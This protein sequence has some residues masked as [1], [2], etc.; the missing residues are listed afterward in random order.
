MQIGTKIRELRKQRNL[1]LDELSEKS[2]VAL[3][4]LSRIENNKMKGTLASHQNICKA[5]NISIAE[6]YQTLENQN[7]TVESVPLRKRAEHVSGS[8]KSSFE[9]LVAKAVGKKILPLLLTIEADGQTQEENNSPGVEK[10][11]YILS[12][13]VNA[14][15]GDNSYELRPGDSLY[16]DAS[17]PHIFRN[18]NA[19]KAEAI[20]VIAPPEIK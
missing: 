20:C 8:K 19:K 7:K 2:G 5:L 3:A 13:S 15:V 10:F 18:K 12:G 14:S 6:M 17:L 1:T 11:V 16:F 4:T 9:L